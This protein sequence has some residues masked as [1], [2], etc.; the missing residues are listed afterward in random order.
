M[1]IFLIYTIGFRRKKRRRKE[2]VVPFIAT[3]D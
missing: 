2:T 1:G 3:R